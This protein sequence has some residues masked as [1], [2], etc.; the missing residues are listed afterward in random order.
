MHAVHNTSIY[1]TSSYSH[2]GNM[3]VRASAGRP[4]ERGYAYSSFAPQNGAPLDHWHN[5]KM[6][7]SIN[8]PS[9]PSRYPYTIRFHPNAGPCTKGVALTNL[10]AGIGL[11]DPEVW[12]ARALPRELAKYTH[13]S[14]RIEWPGYEPETYV[15][16]LVDPV[17]R[18]HVNYA[19]IGREVVHFFKRYADTRNDADFHD[20]LDRGRS[21]GVRLGRNGVGYEQVRLIELYTADGVTYRARFGLV[22]NQL[23]TD[24]NMSWAGRK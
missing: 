9:D 8:H 2:G 21:M 5:E 20:G 13:G 7:L 16:T 18:G 3:D 22:P 10:E 17:K 12:V 14:L 6:M 23:K 24:P 11:R 15:L 1:S 4:A 19:Q